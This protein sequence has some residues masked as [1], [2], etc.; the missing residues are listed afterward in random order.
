MWEE[1]PRFAVR[2]SGPRSTTRRWS[3]RRLASL[4][5]FLAAFLTLLHRLNPELRAR[6]VDLL[7]ALGAWLLAFRAEL[8]LFLPSPGLP[9]GP[10][11]GFGD[12]LLLGLGALVLVGLLRERRPTVE[13]R[14]EELLREIRARL[15]WG[16]GPTGRGAEGRPRRASSP[17]V[18]L[19]LPSDPSAE[20]GASVQ[21]TVAVAAPQ[22]RVG[23]LVRRLGGA[24]ASWFD[25]RRE[26]SGRFQ[27]DPF[28]APRS[29]V[30]RVPCEICEDP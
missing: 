17:A 11:Q 30:A 5:A 13:R 15:A 1:R 7:V 29:P 20:S 25:P 23:D 10:L 3:Y 24:R 2:S 28:R 9:L 14:M 19:Y 12:L 18:V 16:G 22:E 6:A 4:I 26:P 8:N 21:A 27:R